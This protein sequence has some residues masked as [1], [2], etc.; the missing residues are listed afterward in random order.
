MVGTHGEALIPVISREPQE[1]TRYLNHERYIT[2]PSRQPAVSCP[3]QTPGAN[4]YSVTL[5]G[6]PPL[7][8]T[9]TTR[10]C[11]ARHAQSRA[12]NTQCGPFPPAS[13]ALEGICA[14]RLCWAGMEEVVASSIFGRHSVFFPRHWRSSCRVWVRCDLGG[15]II[16]IIA[17]SI[18]EG[19]MI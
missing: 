2:F 14:T 1:P 5:E 18:R 16:G 7:S 3:S 19:A 17:W 10:C 12:T 9:A 6:H 4:L 15:L 13:A 11:V 8:L